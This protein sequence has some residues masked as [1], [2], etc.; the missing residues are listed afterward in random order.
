MPRCSVDQLTTPTED[1][2]V[3]KIQRL[4]RICGGGTLSIAL[5]EAL[6]SSID[7]PEEWCEDNEKC[8]ELKPTYDHEYSTQPFG[9]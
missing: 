8:K 7:P 4:L 5:L 2:A 1:I 6:Q 9:A 3:L